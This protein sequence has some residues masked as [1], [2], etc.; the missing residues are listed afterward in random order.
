MLTTVWDMGRKEN[1]IHLWTNI[2]IPWSWHS[3]VAE[4]RRG[5]KIW[6]NKQAKCICQ[7]IQNA[8]EKLMSGREIRNARMVFCLNRGIR[9]VLTAK[10]PKNLK[11]FHHLHLPKVLESDKWREYF[12]EGT[13]QYIPYS[14]YLFYFSSEKKSWWVFWMLMSQYFIL[15][16]INQNFIHRCY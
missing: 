7:N 2:P 3:G 6:L 9:E 11:L 5:E 12:S 1:E 16:R 15:F 14:Y 8:L 4:V 13:R 10:E